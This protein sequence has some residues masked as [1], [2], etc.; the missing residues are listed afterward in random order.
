VGAVWGGRGRYRYA[1][2]R[3]LTVASTPRRVAF[4]M[5]NPSTADGRRDDPTI[6][7]CCG[8]A[9]TWGYDQVAVYNLF[10]LRA[11]DPRELRRALASGIDPVGPANDRYLEVG[12]AVAD[13]VVCAWGNHG[14]LGGRASE[15][16]AHLRAAGRRLH[17]LG[18]TR[19]GQPRH[20][21][22]LAGDVRPRTLPR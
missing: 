11:T 15:V 18:L 2:W 10:A 20:P 5:L 19:H 6:R 4:V 7:R 8:L 12:S 13:L 21:L 1:L 3:E 17:H 16:I 9:R 22:Y 14:D